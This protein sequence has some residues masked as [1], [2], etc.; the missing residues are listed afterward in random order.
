VALVSLVSV[1]LLAAGAIRIEAFVREI[2]RLSRIGIGEA[3]HACVVDGAG[4]LVVHP[5]IS[6]RK[7][8]LADLP[9]VAAALAAATGPG[10][11]PR[12]G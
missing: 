8:S 11:K 4:N 10:L 7:T 5:D 6:L 3:G 1:V 12:A 2:E 9:H